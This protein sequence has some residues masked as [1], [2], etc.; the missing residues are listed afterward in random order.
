[1][2][3]TPKIWLLVGFAILSFLSLFVNLSPMSVTFLQDGVMIKSV[4]L[5]SQLY[6]DGLRK[7]MTIISINGEVIND[8]EDF[9]EVVN[10]YESLGENETIRTEISTLENQNPIINLYGSE[11]VSQLRVKESPKSKLKTGLDLQGGA[12]AFIRIVGD[13]TD[14]DMNDVISVLD[15]RL[16]A[17]GLTDVEIYK[18]R[19]GDE[20]L[21]GIEI[22]GSSPDELESLIEEQGMFEAKIA[23]QISESG[24]NILFVAISSPAKENFLYNNK[25]LAKLFSQFFFRLFG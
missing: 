2:K 16:N 9:Y 17:Y 15:E 18:V 12:R 1:M 8:L 6:S 14:S 21:I 22:A 20:T 3:F 4:D 19:S 7:D 10:P 5:D 13:V 24:A 23:N 25:K 11:I